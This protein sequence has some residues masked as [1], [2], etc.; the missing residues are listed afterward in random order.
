MYISTNWLKSFINLEKIEI[1][2]KQTSIESERL[3]SYSQFP[4]ELLTLTGFEVEDITTE[5]YENKTDLIVEIDTTPNRSDV[6]NMVGFSREISSLM[7]FP[8]PTKPFFKEKKNIPTHLKF[9]T[10]QNT[11]I[12][13]TS[14]EFV[15]SL[16]FHQMENIKVNDSPTWLKQRLLSNNMNP[17]NN[18]VDLTNYS[19]IEW[20]QPLH[21]YDFDKIKNLTKQ[22]SEKIK[23][24]LRPGYKDEKFLALDDITYILNEKNY[25]ITA[26]DI[27]ISI[28][29]VIGGK[30]T[31]IDETTTNIVLECGNFNS[32]KVRQSS[33]KLGI[34][35]DAS[36]YFGKGVAHTT[37]NL[38]FQHTIKLLQLLC[39]GNSII[40]STIFYSQAKFINRTLTLNFANVCETLGEIYDVKAK[41]TRT[42]TASEILTCLNRLNFT[43]DQIT[44]S[45]CTLQI[46]EYRSHDIEYE[47]DIIEEIGRIYG[48]NNFIPRLPTTYRLGK[49][50]YEQQLINNFQKLLINQG[51]NELIHYSLNS[52]N[53]PNKIKLFNPLGVE[54]SALR[55]TLMFNLLDSAIYNTNQR[56][57]SL[58]GFEIGRVFNYKKNAEYTLL[59]GIFGGSAYKTE[60]NKPLQTLS[61]YEAKNTII[62]LFNNMNINNVNWS[63]LTQNLGPQFHP[64][65]SALLHYKHKEIGTFTQINPLYAKQN[66]LSRSIYLF[67]INVTY[68]SQL[69]VNQAQKYKNFSTYPKINKDISLEV[70][71]NL[72]NTQLLTLIKQIIKIKK[73]EELKIS[74]KLFDNYGQKENNNKRILGYTLTYQSNTRTLLKGEIDTLTQEIVDTLKSKLK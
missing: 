30:T 70:S 6:N 18:V 21:I 2:N 66:N 29:G 59:A 34:N 43:V 52:G 20:G 67:E 24:G 74:V 42:L 44:D 27:A 13:Q 17:I 51:F 73:T 62:T 8:L 23:L 36:S 5:T 19:I 9:S 54:Y 47:I 11:N 38:A 61:W 69:H 45:N 71:T 4:T 58:S 1:K 55:S 31:A 33:R 37:S 64:G 12:N 32:K 48:F 53:L 65:R 68:L 40:S 72:T 46:P 63:Q 26:N 14:N 10:E 35:T 28:A 15:T 16:F 56:N 39:H 22:N 49:I 3:L 41:Q 50:S 60:W 25:V 7:N 57:S